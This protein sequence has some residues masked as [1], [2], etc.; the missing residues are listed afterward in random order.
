MKIDAKIFLKILANW[1]QKSIKRITHGNQLGFI[2]DIQDLFNIQ[3]SIN[4][5]YHINRLK[6]KNYIIILIDAEKT[7]V[8]IQLS[9]MT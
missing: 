3:K 5:T 9:F 7:L 2:P 8:K 4:V 1:I 6:N